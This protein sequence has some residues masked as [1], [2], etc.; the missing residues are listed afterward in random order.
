M[1][2]IAGKVFFDT[3][4]V[5]RN[6]LTKM[7]TSIA[8]RGPD[9][10]GFFISQNHKVGLVNRRLAIIDLSPKGHM[11]MIWKNRY[12]I[13]YNGEVF[14]F[15]EERERLKKLGY[16]FNSN[17]DTEVILA[18]YDKYD[19]RCLEYLRGMFAFAIYDKVKNTIFL[20]R[21]RLG[22][23][24]LK[25][26]Y[27]GGVFI[28]ASELKAILTQREVKRMPDYNAITNYLTFGYVPAPLTGFENIKKLEP[29]SY[30][31][32]D[33]KHATIKKRRYWKPDFST[34]L[35]LPESVWKEKIL[36]TLEE[37]VKLRMISDVPIGVFLSGGV[38]SSAVTALM[39][40]N[41]PSP[42]K[43]FTIGF[44]EKTHDERE[45]AEKIARLY[46]T[47]HTELIVK[48]A[49]IDTL[50]MLIKQFE[51]PHANS[52]SI[53]SYL[54]AKMA[55]QKVTVVLNGDGGDEIF[56][57]YEARHFRLQR[58][59]AAD[60]LGF[61]LNTFGLPLAKVLGYTKAVK[62]LEKRQTALADR[63]LSYNWYF[64]GNDKAKQVVREKFI[65]ANT[66]DARDQA[67]YY[68]LVQYFPDDLLAKS[69]LSSMLVSLEERSPFAD[70]KMVELA[71]QIPFGLKLKGGITKY[72][73]KKALVDLVPK[74]NLY[75]QKKGFSVPLDKWF[76]GNIGKYARNVLTTKNAF[77]T[78][79][80][81]MKKL[82]SYNDLQRWNLLALELWFK[83]Y[84]S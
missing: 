15:Q 4:I 39:A 12:V 44:E 36:D 80:V 25:Y 69:D 23:K 84:F 10:E 32:I 30:L 60:K 14:N 64:E 49:S 41:S 1:C 37:S 43:T 59:V 50:P 52:S 33:I 22:K 18:L 11:P 2:G 9:D 57:G 29:G 28:F 7:S 35:D 48:P 53:L 72:I 6:D 54:V 47:D 81:D 3:S 78:K 40:R 13:T 82:R 21:D 38:D 70:H 83:E 77:V 71:S 5:Q 27:T 68:D 19:T 63:Y 42:I 51:E 31:L 65:E 79:F 17:S 62:F 46:K 8:H 45:Y 76:K 66:T 75:R 26:Y 61:V 34:K 20:A 55:R 56:A 58:D 67:L 73:L 16:K 24:P 74:G